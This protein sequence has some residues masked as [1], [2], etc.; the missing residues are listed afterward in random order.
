MPDG[1]GDADDGERG[2]GFLERHFDSCGDGSGFGSEW[3]FRE[4]MGL[5]GL[6]SECRHCR[7]REEEEEEEVRERERQRFWRRR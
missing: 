5:W 2:R 1:A 6:M 3:K 7:R 4:E